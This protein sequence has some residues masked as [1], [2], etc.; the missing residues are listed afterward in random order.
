MGYT[1]KPPSG[2]TAEFDPA[3]VNDRLAFANL[4]KAAVVMITKRSRSG[5]AVQPGSDDACDIAAALLGGR[6][7]ARHRLAVRCCNR[8]GVAD[9]EDLGMS[10]NR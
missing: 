7:D 10:G 9:G 1:P 5:F 6:G 4:R 3:K 2:R 8:D